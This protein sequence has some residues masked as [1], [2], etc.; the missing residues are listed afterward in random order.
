MARNLPAPRFIT[1]SNWRAILASK[2]PSK[3]RKFRGPFS[4]VE[5][6][7]LAESQRLH[8]EVFSMPE[9]W[10]LNRKNK[11]GT[12]YCAPTRR[13]RQS[14]KRARFAHAPSKSERRFG[15][16]AEADLDFAGSFSAAG[17]S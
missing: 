14:H 16:R 1:S 11:E 17:A 8:V 4:F 2:T 5:I 6:A 12:I 3:G 9:A 7:E 13:K 10:V 15:Y